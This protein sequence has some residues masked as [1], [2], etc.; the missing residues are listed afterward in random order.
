[1]DKIRF[2]S[3]FEIL[4]KLLTQV[5]EFELLLS[6]EGNFPSFDYFD[7]TPELLR[8]NIEGTYIEQEKLFDLKSSLITIIECVEYINKQEE[9]NFSSLRNLTEQVDIDNNIIEQIQKIVDDKGKIR[10]SAST[11]I[12]DI[13][14]KLISKLSSIDKRINT[15]LSQAKKIRMGKE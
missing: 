14:K 13:R 3:N 4:T 2:T 7:L 11:T 12:K 5:E 6:M 10:D 1:V 9:G 15:S 8:I